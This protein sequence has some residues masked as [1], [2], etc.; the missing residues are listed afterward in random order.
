MPI[1]L[2]QLNGAHLPLQASSPYKLA[3]NPY[4]EA[5]I[6]PHYLFGVKSGDLA[7]NGTVSAA[8]FSGSQDILNIF[9]NM[10][11]GKNQWDQSMLQTMIKDN[12][13]SIQWGSNAAT[14]ILAQGSDQKS[15]NDQGW[16]YHMVSTASDTI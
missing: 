2:W 12:I 16:L 9:Q 4:P 13:F 10:K 11:A 5:A 15:F 14:G 3:G 1:M 7:G 8:F 6:F